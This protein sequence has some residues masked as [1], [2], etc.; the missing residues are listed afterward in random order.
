MGWF[1]LV[2]VVMDRRAE[3][4]MADATAAQQQQPAS[5]RFS[6]LG[7][8]ASARERGVWPSVVLVLGRCCPPRHT[9]TIG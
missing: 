9:A 8:S 6:L 4:R 7:P 1:G 3:V 2:V 5:D